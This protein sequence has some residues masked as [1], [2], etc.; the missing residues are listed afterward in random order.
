[1]SVQVIKNVEL[2]IKNLYSGLNSIINGKE[3]TT[4]ALAG[5][6]T[7]INDSDWRVSMLNLAKRKH[8]NKAKMKAMYEGGGRWDN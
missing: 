5:V 1:M 6:G 8:E 2:R 7:P 3:A 4:K